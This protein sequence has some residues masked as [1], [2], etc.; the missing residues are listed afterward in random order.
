MRIRRVITTREGGSSAGAYAS[1]NLGDGVGDDPDSVAANRH[2]M[3]AELGLAD[4][5]VVWMEQVHGRT[6]SVVTA[7]RTEPV[8]V[9]DALVT[10][11]PELAVAAL[12]ADCVP[13]LLADPRAG[14]VSAVH[15]GRVGSRLG[16][17]GAALSAMVGLGARLDRVEALLGPAICGECYEV[18]AA[19]RDD[20]EAHLPGSACR[21][22]GGTP[23]LDLR[24]GLWRALSETGV[25]GID[26][27][28]RCTAED[29]TLYSHRRDDV[30]GRLAAVTWFEPS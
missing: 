8:E 4:E 18:P 28:P 10:G 13:V 23:G 20:I 22:R 6:A 12:V 29:E 11:T 21:T 16:V 2:R 27:D 15:A 3:A 24:A 30:T 5:R 26:V 9:T 17:L 25:A 14:V 1:F 7:P 19:M